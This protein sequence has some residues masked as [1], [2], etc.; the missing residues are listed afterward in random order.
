M[1]TEGSS[2]KNETRLEADNMVGDLMQLRV[3]KSSYERP[4]SKLA[5]DVVQYISSLAHLVEMKQCEIKRLME[6]IESRIMKRKRVNA[7]KQKQNI[8]V[9]LKQLSEIK[10]MVKRILSLTRGIVGMLQ[11]IDDFCKERDKL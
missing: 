2:N 1:G 3:S 7:I 10:F 8:N 9:A 4:I 5:D 11:E 6:T